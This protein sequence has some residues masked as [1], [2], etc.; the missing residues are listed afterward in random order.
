MVSREIFG[1]KK[2]ST[3]RSV[4]F[5]SS[6]LPGT[7]VKEFSRGGRGERRER[8]GKRRIRRRERERGSK[9]MITQIFCGSA[10]RHVPRIIQENCSPPFL[11]NKINTEKRR[12]RRGRGRGTEGGED[13]RIKWGAI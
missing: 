6:A 11:K 12:K 2:A 10:Q 9:D 7:I 5:L 13:K 3:V 8:E 1:S 4:A